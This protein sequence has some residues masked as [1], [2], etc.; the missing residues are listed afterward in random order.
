MKFTILILI[1]LNLLSGCN[2]K[3]RIASGKTTTTRASLTYAGGYKPA[4]P[5]ALIGEGN[6]SYISYHG[7]APGH[8]NSLIYLNNSTGDYLGRCDECVT[9]DGS[10]LE[11]VGS[12]LF[13]GGFK[14][15]DGQRESIPTLD[16]LSLENPAA[17]KVIKSLSF[18]EF[19]GAS[20]IDGDYS[21]STYCLPMNSAQTVLLIDSVT[22]KEIS[23]VY[24]NGMIEDCDIQNNK[25][26]VADTYGISIFDITNSSTP[27]PIWVSAI[28]NMDSILIEGNYMY[29]A[30]WG[31]G[32][33][34]YDISNPGAPV[35]I[36]STPTGGHT[37]EV[38]KKGNYLFLADQTGGM[39]VIDISNPLAPNQVG[40]IPTSSGDTKSIYIQ[41]N[42]LFALDNADGVK[43]IDISD[44]TSPHLLTNWDKYG[45]LRTEDMTIKDN[46]AFIA[47]SFAGSV[48]SLDISNPTKPVFLDEVVTGS[49]T[50][51]LET[52]GNALFVGSGGAGLFSIDIT[53]PSNMTVLD[54]YFVGGW[55]VGVHVEGNYLYLTN[56]TSI[57]ILDISDPSNLTSTASYIF[58]GGKTSFFSHYA[59][60]I[61]F[62]PT[63]TNGLDLIDV[64]DPYNPTLLYTIA[65]ENSISKAMTDPS[66]GIL[67]LSDGSAGLK[68]YNI[69]NPLAPQQVMS[70]PNIKSMISLNFVTG[71]LI[72]ADYQYAY[73]IDVSDLNHPTIKGDFYLTHG[74]KLIYHNN[75]VYCADGYMGFKILQKVNF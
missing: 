10:Y 50:F 56:H 51:Y 20:I 6:Y 63:G 54:Q 69:A 59:N 32:Y 71:Y 48:I 38:V 72:V 19:P 11:I 28:A 65:A 36:S 22:F 61:L 16:I 18:P 25:M 55:A 53:D 12:K 9:Q 41:D 42:T 24:V 5:I 67:Y 27:N 40:V 13:L 60:G 64:S 34:I 52:K 68:G 21:S 7:S 73:V 66:T 23:R 49:Q 17:P 37:W 30:A 43:V 46:F 45:S 31:D 75:Y 15:I 62:A 8:K 39:K 70:L 29:L 4:L 3:F 35:L 44:P 2:E 33:K 58:P 1:F 74:H 47:N 26:Y 57:E 14:H